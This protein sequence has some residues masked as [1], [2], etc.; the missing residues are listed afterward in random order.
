MTLLPHPG[1]KSPLDH[2]PY[3]LVACES[4]SSAS[5]G[6]KYCSYLF[7]LFVYQA[8]IQF[9]LE[10]RAEKTAFSI[11]CSP[12][13][14]TSLSWWLLK[15][16]SFHGKND[17]W[18]QEL[19]FQVILA[20]IFFLIWFPLKACFVGPVI[21]ANDNLS[22]QHFVSCNDMLC[23]G[24]IESNRSRKLNC[25]FQPSSLPKLWEKLLSSYKK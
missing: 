21:L 5:A 9:N 24:K 18:T 4:L 14:L 17:D 2:N 3:I 22:R 12:P 15:A 19:H 23:K 7:H 11:P 1:G 8:I 10:G 20:L 16:A 13:L 25:V 6:L